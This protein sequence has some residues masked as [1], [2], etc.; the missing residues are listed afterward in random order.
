MTPGQLERLWKLL[1]AD[2]EVTIDSCVGAGALLA[3]SVVIVRIGGTQTD[4]NFDL[5]YQPSTE[6]ST[7]EFRE[8]IGGMTEANRLQLE[9]VIHGA[10]AEADAAAL[11]QEKRREGVRINDSKRMASAYSL[12][13]ENADKDMRYRRPVGA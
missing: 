4:A 2:R 3:V 6:V 7:A 8:R 11:C 9:V 1:S 5:S 10:I 13:D 12:S